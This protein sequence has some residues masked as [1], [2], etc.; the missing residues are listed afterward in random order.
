VPASFRTLVLA[1]AEHIPE[2][3]LDRVDVSG[4]RA[5]AF[6]QAD[7]GAPRLFGTDARL[8]NL[9]ALAVHGP[10]LYRDLRK[11]TGAYHLREHDSRNDAPFGRGAVVRTWETPDGTA[12]ALDPD[13]PCAL[14]LCRLLVRLAEIYPLPAHDPAYGKPDLPPRQAGT[15]TA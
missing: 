11:L 5:F 7:D 10:M 4:P 3:R 6:I 1:I 14:P 15:E 13:Y 9:M 12:V 2:R 8:R